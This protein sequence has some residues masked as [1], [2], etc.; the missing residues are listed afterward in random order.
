MRVEVSE[1]SL[2]RTGKDG[3]GTRRA[4]GGNFSQS[5]NI[6]HVA[7]LQYFLRSRQFFNQ[8]SLPSSKQLLENHRHSK[9][10]CN[11]RLTPPL[12]MEGIALF[13]RR[14]SRHI[15]ISEPLSCPARC[16]LPQYLKDCLFCG[17]LIPFSSKYWYKYLFHFSLYT[18][19]THAHRCTHYQW[20][21]DC[22]SF[23]EKALSD[24]S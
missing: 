7:P 11:V 5:E 24:C 8:F 2:R 18:V 23:E 1:N 20:G 17:I 9:H 6:C 3:M 14:C 10:N 19:H 4:S 16:F 22:S 21:W 12:A 13:W 15:P